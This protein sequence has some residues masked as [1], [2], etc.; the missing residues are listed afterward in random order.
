M[1]SG[2]AGEGAYLLFGPVGWCE[3]RGA[4][5]GIRAVPVSV[6]WCRRHG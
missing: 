1:A 5:F 2:G 3:G 4:G 6:E